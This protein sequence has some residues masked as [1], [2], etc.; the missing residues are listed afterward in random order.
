MSPVK[1]EYAKMHYSGSIAATVETPALNT[2][3]I[4]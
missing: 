1:S 3:N 4:Q 2:P